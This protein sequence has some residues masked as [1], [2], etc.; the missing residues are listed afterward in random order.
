MGILPAYMS[1]NRIHTWCPW[2]GWAEED[3]RAPGTGI[4]DGC[5]LPCGYLVSNLG[6]LQK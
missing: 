2:G 1:V 5:Q 6:V 3:I 4:T